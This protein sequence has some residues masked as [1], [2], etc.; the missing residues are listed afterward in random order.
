MSSA[1]R[2]AYAAP[3]FALAAIGIPVYVHL[4]KFYTDVVGVPVG[5]LGALLMAARLLDGL[6]DPTIGALS[7]AT[8]TRWGRRRPYVIG[9]A[10][11]LAAALYLLFTPPLG[12]PA[13][14]PWWFG[15]WLFAV[16]V[17]WTLVVVPYESLGPEL[18]Y[19]YD[20]RTSLLALRDGA[21]LLGT[22][23]AAASPTAAAALV[24]MPPGPAAEA[25]RF[26]LVALSYGPLIVA[27]CLWCVWSVRERQDSKPPR[28]QRLR[29][30]WRDMLAN[31]PF[32]ILLSSYAV[33]ALGSNLP[34]TLVLFY[35]EYVLQ[36][37][38]ADYF[39]LLYLVTGI[40]CLPMW[41]A[42]SK[43]FD[44]KHAWLTATAVNTA[45]FSGV[46]F[47][48][49]GDA[50]V[51]AALVFV[52]GIGFGATIALPSSMQADVID[53]DELLSGRRRE[54]SYLG[55]WA[56]ARKMSA[57]IGVGVGLHVLDLAGYVPNAEQTPHVRDV[58]V[59][60]YALVPC[61]CNAAGFAIALAY[62]IGRREHAA[63]RAAV[64]RRALGHPVC[65]PLSPDRVL[66]GPQPC[67]SS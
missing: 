29:A 46:Y 15:I 25:A 24:Q 45:A 10:I 14:A 54:G 11:P 30:T 19:D 32:L 17:L 16:F 27:A 21:L 48:G 53:Y 56:V 3:A 23:V 61:A 42:V 65:D 36:S 40:A 7:D 49:P 33:A 34:A 4:P 39:M 35:V 12:S 64:D 9:A 51:Y 44:K 26:R 62:P 13:L 18:T 47:L 6:L 28:R 37:P 20:Q 38:S 60:L 57:A 63:I 41:V 1:V 67:P 59:A 50:A 66:G 43:R 58:L 5:T 8:R 22:L 31:R 55:V 2:A 52:S